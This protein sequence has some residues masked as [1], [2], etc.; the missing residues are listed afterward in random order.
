M[1]KCCEKTHLQKRSQMATKHIKRSSA[2]P[3]IKEMQNKTK[4]DSTL[5]LLEG[6]KMQIKMMNVINLQRVHEDLEDLKGSYGSVA[7][8][9]L[10]Y[11]WETAWVSFKV[12]CS[13]VLQSSHSI[14]RNLPT[15]T[16]AH[17]TKTDAHT[18]THTYTHMFIKVTLV[19]PNNQKPPRCSTKGE[20]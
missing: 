20:P 12:E 17:V 11:L 5:H 3:V 2:L 18:H 16:K 7:M 14:P 4:W 9:I 19:F 1:S 8:Q 6:L 10:Q 13:S 15:E